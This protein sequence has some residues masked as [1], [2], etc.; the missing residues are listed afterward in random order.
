VR[1][2][3]SRDARYPLCNGNPNARAEPA[4]VGNLGADKL[5]VS[6]RQSLEKAD[7]RWGNFCEDRIIA[8]ESEIDKSL[9][10]V[11]VTPMMTVAPYCP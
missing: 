3:T 10:K 9:R 7:A 8:T 2:S 6:T 11:R 5:V 4:F 1:G